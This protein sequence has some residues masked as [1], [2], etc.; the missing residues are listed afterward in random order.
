MN[1]NK[2]MTGPTK[3]RAAETDGIG[4]KAANFRIRSLPR[5]SLLGELRDTHGRDV[6]LARRVFLPPG[7]IH[8][9]MMSYENR[10]AASVIRYRY[11][12]RDYS[13]RYTIAHKGVHCS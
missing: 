1:R 7:C 4:A 13:P 8:T 11:R 3:D 9:L 2:G 5:V 6:I 10:K 12:S